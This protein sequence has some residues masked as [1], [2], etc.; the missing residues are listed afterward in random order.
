VSRG[1]WLGGEARSENSEEERGR[2]RGEKRNDL[3]EIRMKRDG[4]NLVE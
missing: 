2:L 3:I 4:N 1:C